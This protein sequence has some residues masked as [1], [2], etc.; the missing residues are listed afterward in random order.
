MW[1]LAAKIKLKLNIKKIKYK[2]MTYHRCI[3]I[4]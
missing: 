1:R 2:K 3:T 4:K